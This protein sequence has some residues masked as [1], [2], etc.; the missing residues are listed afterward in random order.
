MPWNKGKI[1]WKKKKSK[2][3]NPT[4]IK[5]YPKC[6]IDMIYDNKYTFISS[7][8]KNKSCQTYANIGKM[9]VKFQKYIKELHEI[10]NHLNCKFIAYD[11]RKG[12]FIHVN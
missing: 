6:N 11:F 4:Y 8:E 2:Y 7:I 1:S 5:K 12:E 9:L 10:I 3:I